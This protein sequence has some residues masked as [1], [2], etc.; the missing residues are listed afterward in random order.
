MVQHPQIKNRNYIMISTGAD[1]FWQKSASIYNKNSQQ[2]GYRGAI[3]VSPQL[4]LYLICS[5]VKSWKHYLKDQEKNQRWLLWSLLFNIV[6][7]SH[8]SQTRKRNKRNPNWKEVIKSITVCRPHDARTQNIFKMP[9]QRYQ[10]EQLNSVKLQGTKLTEMCCISRYQ[11][12]T[13]RKRT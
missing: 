10:H 8:S 3:L 1:S 13:I 12:Q 5:T 4:T 6:L 2:N 7:G 9:P 11:Q